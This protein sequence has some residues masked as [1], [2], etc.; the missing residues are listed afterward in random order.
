MGIVFRAED[1]LSGK[2]IALK[3]LVAPTDNLLFASRDSGSDTQ[4]SLARE[5]QI[6]ASLQHPYIIRV[7]DYGFNEQRQPFFTMDFLEPAFTLTQAARGRSVE[8]RVKLLVE[9]LQALSYLHRRRI[10]HRD[11]KPTN[12]LVA[13]DSVKM[14][15]FGLSVSVQQANPSEGRTTGTLAYIAP[16]LL[17]ERPASEASDLYAVGLMAY[18]LFVGEFPYAIDS[19]TKLIEQI[20]HL[21]LTIPSSVAPA[22]AAII[23]QLTAKDP[24][25]RY[26]RAEDVIA[27]LSSAVST[28]IPV[29]TEAIRESFLQA[30]QLVGRDGELTQLKDVLSRTL[31]KQL[32]LWLIGGESG[33]GKSRLLNELRTLAM[34]KGAV[35]LNGQANS[36][37]N[38]PFQLWRETLRWLSLLTEDLTDHEVSV[39][40]VL[41]A[42]I[43]KLLNRDVPDAPPLN[44][45]STQDRLLKVIE[46]VFSR[47]K[48]P[49]VLVLEDLHWIENESLV[50]LQRLCKL[51]SDVPLL[52][53]GSYRDD[54]KPDLP[55]LLPEM[56]L[57]KLERL[58]ENEITDLSES[59]LG[60]AGRK[61]QIVELIRRETEGNIFF[62]IEVVR[63]LAEEA[64]QLSKIGEI[65]LP[66]T[67]FAGG[68]RRVIQ[69]RLSQ[70]PQQDYP[71]LQI[72]AVVGRQLDLPIL[73]AANPSLQLEQ[74]L[75]V[76]NNA[77][78][79]EVRDGRWRFAHDKLREVVL[80]DLPAGERQALHRRVGELIEATH[81][82]VS[83]YV[84]ALAYHFSQGEVWEKAVEYLIKAGDDAARLNAYVDARAHYMK[85]VEAFTRL[86]DNEQNRRRRV[87]TTNK[88]TSVSIFSESPDIHLARLAEA[89]T[90]VKSLAPEGGE[91]AA[92]DRLRLARV[93]YWVGRAHYYRNQ[94]RE[95]V[96]YFRN[97]LAVAQ[98]FKD[99]ELLAVPAS[100]LGRVMVTQGY[101]DKAYA[102]LSQ[103]MTP[104]EMQGNW[105]E[106]AFTVT[107][108]GITLAERAQ[109][110]QGIAESKRGLARAIE[111]KNSP[112]IA[113]CHAL[114]ALVYY[115]GRDTENMME[116]ARE[117]LK[118]AEAAGDYLYIYY[119]YGLLGLACGR[120][121]QE[122]SAREYLAKSDQ[123]G[124][125]FGERRVSADLFA[126]I[127]AD[128]ARLHGRHDEAIAT[129]QK[130][131]EA[132]KAT[133]GLY[134]LG[135]SHSVWAQSLFAKDK[136]QGQE[137]ES[138]MVESVKAFE[139][140]G[141]LLECARA[142]YTWGLIACDLGNVVSAKEHLEKALPQIET[143]GLAAEIEQVRTALAKL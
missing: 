58:K 108:R 131:I 79:L 33:I 24:A 101:Y 31:D 28:P 62:I 88:L 46:D 96:G 56:K 111:T 84:V 136:S 32:N 43:A 13:D 68:V 104:L 6:L 118:V 71:L 69:R 142:H 11:I 42:D 129:A 123:L 95:A 38:S 100:V 116:Q 50:L 55:S 94:L 99:P 1:R 103:A 124:Q 19:L 34:V 127:A 75:T 15:D 110:D 74:W 35:V 77:A 138:H 120:L 22:I 29:E 52:I 106:W 67:L 81:P 97:V 9:T 122:D 90:I 8:S 112:T 86:P 36:E 57:L 134:P 72:A 73:Q 18:E 61:P 37:A 91:L 140:G 20:I 4:L 26:G 66:R 137:I 41:V 89:E 27:A 115:V 126:A 121:G 135:L 128:N 7:L 117:C 60:S 14:L 30:A 25:Q 107:Y 102:L 98:E 45:K 59:M 87:D 109:Y 70:V 40:K 39:L 23:R 93:H 51:R 125:S 47:Q 54:E 44:P 119:G 17:M 63:A 141:A 64:G 10:L 78:V 12:V 83:E 139:G 85:A 2:A 53:L 92:E 5:F 133:G 65:T 16:E 21:D 113:G 80:D 49:I 48:T 114:C 143:S 82:G 105:T 132:A 76:C 3:Q 130:A